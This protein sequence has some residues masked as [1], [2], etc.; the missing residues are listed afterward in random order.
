MA[1]TDL[2]DFPPEL[3]ESVAANAEAEADRVASF[4]DRVGLGPLPGGTRRLPSDFLLNLGAALRL[5]AW[6]VAGITVHREDGLPT[7]ADAVRRVLADAAAGTV[8]ATTPDPWLS[9]ADFRLSID[10]LAWTGRRDLAAEV[11]IE[12]PD[13]DT[14]VESLAQFLWKHRAT[15]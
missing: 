7:P 8:R 10:R 6:E 4:L 14:L 12:V 15:V 11:V 1:A 2:S 9:R 3:I 5:R 13:E